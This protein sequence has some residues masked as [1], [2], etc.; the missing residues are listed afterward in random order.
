MTRA[1]IHSIYANLGI[2]YEQLALAQME[3][4]EVQNLRTAVTNLVLRDIPFGPNSSTILCDISTGN[5]RP[6]VPLK[7]QRPL[8]DLIHNLSHPSIRASRNLK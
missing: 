8:F 2:D 7:F 1:A 5:P 3:D 6:I 4:E